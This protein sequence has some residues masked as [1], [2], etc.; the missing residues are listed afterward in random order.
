MK[1]H[2]TDD[3]TW[4]VADQDGWIDGDFKTPQAALAAVP[5]VDF[6]PGISVTMGNG[7]RI[8]RIGS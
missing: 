1:I 8:G 5:W 6:N 2:E 4:V 3:G 7:N